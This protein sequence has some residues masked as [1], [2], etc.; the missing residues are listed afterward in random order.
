MVSSQIH[1]QHVIRVPG[2]PTSLGP[3]NLWTHPIEKAKF[4][5]IDLREEYN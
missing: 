5:V 4:L 2:N 3:L 1:V